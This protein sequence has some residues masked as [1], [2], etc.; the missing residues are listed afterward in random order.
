MVS[1]S[2]KDRCDL[3][4]NAFVLMLSLVI[5]FLALPLQTNITADCI[6][7]RIDSLM[8]LDENP[9]LGGV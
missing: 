7:L 8:A 2:R 6:E 3:L 9:Y 4:L 5:E 1:V